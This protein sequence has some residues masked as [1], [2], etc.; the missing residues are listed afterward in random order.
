MVVLIRDLS[1]AAK[2]MVNEENADESVDEGP[3]WM[4][5]ILAATL[6]M[7]IVGFIGCGVTTWLLFQKRV[8]LAIRT[9][10]STYIPEV[11]QSLLDPGEK[12]A[13]VAQLE[14]FTADLERG[15]YENWQAAGVMQRLVRLPVLQ[16][17]E[18]SAIESFIEKE[19]G[20]DAG[21]AIRDLSRLR[22]AVE[23]DKATSIDV[24]D[25]LKPALVIDDSP[26]GRR[27]NE[28]LTPDLAKDVA[29]RAK[30][31]ADRSDIPEKGFPDVKINVIIRRQIEAGLK[32][33]SI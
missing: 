29:Q 3:G 15:K 23:L 20:D 9:L 12:K 24:E 5:I 31:V 30:L 6:L 1:L 7:G 22:R 33:G 16:W 21:P 18:L 13:A 25:V 4:P 2:Q 27:L 8:P 14:E 11:E 10:R 19:F 28:K 17:G 26:M 32:E